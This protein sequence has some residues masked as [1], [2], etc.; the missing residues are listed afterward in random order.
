M[1]ITDLPLLIDCDGVLGDFLTMVERVAQQHLGLD[2]ET[3]DHKALVINQFGEHAD[4]IKYELNTP[5][6]AM[7]IEPIQGAAG[8]ISA[9]GMQYRVIVLTT[10]WWSS[11]TWDFERRHWLKTHM[12][13][14]VKDVIF[15]K[16]KT[17]VNG[18][19]L[20]EDSYKNATTWANAWRRK[21]VLFD[22]PANRGLVTPS[23]VIRVRDWA[24]AYP[25]IL[26][27]LREQE[28]A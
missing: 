11:P 27:I 2:Y 16:D 7:S 18:R 21:A 19:V 15:A 26:D 24:E 5:G 8:A 22:A 28:V 13:I 20:V 3:S 12:G 17:L 4:A 1:N 6:T 25:V 9:L 14:S 23:N 10:P